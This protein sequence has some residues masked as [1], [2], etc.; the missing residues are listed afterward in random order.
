MHPCNQSL[1]P[2]FFCARIYK[3]QFEEQKKSTKS[4]SFFII[5]IQ[6]H[7][8]V[9]HFNGTRTHRTCKFYFI[10]CHSFTIILIITSYILNIRLNHMQT[11]VTNQIYFCNGF[12]QVFIM[13]MAN[14]KKKQ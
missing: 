1:H 6:T 10:C 13:A 2:R 3:R 7:C 5:S 14:S 11:V 8:K 4:Q 12:E 9:H